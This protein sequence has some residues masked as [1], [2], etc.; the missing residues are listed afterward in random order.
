MICICKSLDVRCILLVDPCG[1]EALGLVD[2]ACPCRSVVPVH[3][4]LDVL[5][6]LLH[7][8]KILDLLETGLI[9][10]A[11]RHSAVDRD[12]AAVCNGASGGRCVENLADGAGSTS[13]EAGILIVLR[14]VLGIQHL[15]QPLDLH[16]VVGGILVQRSDVLKDIGHLVDGVIASFGSRTVA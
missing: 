7:C 6:V 16:A 15:H 13:E 8:R 14:V 9:G 10:L 3:A 11:S 4:D 12:G 1:E 5:A 2:L